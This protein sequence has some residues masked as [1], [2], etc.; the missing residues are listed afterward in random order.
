MDNGKA[1]VLPLEGGAIGGVRQTN[2]AEAGHEHGPEQT[3]LRQ[4]GP[5]KIGAFGMTRSLVERDELAVP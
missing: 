4:L 5:E 2:L 1:G 3:H